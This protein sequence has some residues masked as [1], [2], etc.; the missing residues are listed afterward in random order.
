MASSKA[1][2][3]LCLNLVFFTLVSSSY[4]P[5]VP[6]TTPCPPPPSTPSHHDGHHGGYPTPSG[7]KCPNDAL[8]IAACADVLNG[9]VHAVVGPS[10]SEC[11]SLLDGLVGLDAALCLCTRLEVDVLGLVHLDLPISV[12]LLV[13]FCDIAG[14][15]SN[16]QCPNY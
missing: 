14:V 12:T 1:T 10:R 7:G 11:C 16:Y 3:V 8:K 6:T 15:P 5:S 2:F 9:L 13:N 4:V